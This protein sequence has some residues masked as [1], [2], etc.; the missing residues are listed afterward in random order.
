MRKK[1]A[2]ASKFLHYLF[3][4]FFLCSKTIVLKP[5]DQVTDKETQYIA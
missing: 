4:S 5:R 2:L 1:L 3:F